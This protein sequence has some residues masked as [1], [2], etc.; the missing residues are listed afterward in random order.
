[1]PHNDGILL[2]LRCVVMA[3]WLQHS[4]V[5][6]MRSR[7]MRVL[8]SVLSGSAGEVAP[9]PLFA[10]D[11]LGLEPPALHSSI[12]GLGILRQG[13]RQQHQVRLDPPSFLLPSQVNLKLT[14]SDFVSQSVWNLYLTSTHDIK[15]KFVKW[16][17]LK[18]QILIFF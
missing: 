7:P 2:A 5:K 10:G 16:K 15:Q 4:K 11:L 3:Y 12:P 18:Y 9:G 17:V 6:P 14:E 13:V 1:M 8:Y